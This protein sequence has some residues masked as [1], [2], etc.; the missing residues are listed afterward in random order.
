MQRNSF[1]PQ[2]SDSQAGDK[3]GDSKTGVLV[4]GFCGSE[5]NI[6]VRNVR[7][8][9]RSESMKMDRGMIILRQSLDE[10]APQSFFYTDKIEGLVKLGN[11]SDSDPKPKFAGLPDVVNRTKRDKK[12]IL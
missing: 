5:Q 4:F 9:V 12:L 8:S 1:R 2:S 10:T 6:L 7:S 3:V 11:E